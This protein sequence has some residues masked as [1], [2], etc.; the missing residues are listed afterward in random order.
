MKQTAAY[1][2]S[3]T[4]LQEESVTTQQYEIN[5]YALKKG[6]L[7]DGEYPEPSVSARKNKLNERPQMR[8]LMTDIRNGKIGTLLVY[9]RDRLARKVEEHLELYKLFKTHQVELHFIAENEPPMRFDIF[10]ELMEL[11]IGVMNQREGEQ[12]NLRI[13]DTKLS[14]FL[15]GKSIG[16]LP[17]GYSSDESHTKI[18]KDNEG[19]NIVKTI[20]TEWNTD[21]YANLEKLAQQLDKDG[22]KRGKKNW[23]RNNISD[24]LTNPIYMGIRIA[25]FDNRQVTRSVEDLAIITPEEF[26]L[27]QE[28]I[29]KRKKPKKVKQKYDYLLS[30]LLLCDLCDKK[31]LSNN[32]R[33][34]EGKTYATYEC[35]EHN[36]RLDQHETESLVYLKTKSFFTELLNTHFDKL[37]TTQLKINLAEISKVKSIFE[38][39]LEQ[40]EGKLVQATN[41]WIKKVNK[42]N[43]E[44]I[45]ELSK[46]VKIIKDK[47]FELD[48]RKQE[49]IEVPKFI[50][51]IEAE[52]LKKET[53][54][55]LP[56][57]RKKA[58]LKDL[59]QYILVD[60]YTTRIVFKH[61]YLEANEVVN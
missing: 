48:V 1:Y 60:D 34:R 19:L 39:E 29:E 6:I 5:Q 18:I 35:K 46:K 32:A 24:V 14:N 57:E 42:S 13:A 3:S 33:M 44:K 38:I 8:Q 11:F 37:Y 27:A 22:I 54:E 36:I 53:W 28:L 4:Q 49:F 26:N 41:M 55:L 50:E 2:R 61:P 30:D 10:G 7:I 31:P 17:F 25:N 45:L 12:I 9:K 59:I 23:T 20:F 47:L 51:E 21:Q 16:N 56:F 40:A 43:E 58:L 52:M 15:R